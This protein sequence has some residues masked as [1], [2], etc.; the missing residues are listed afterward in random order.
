M[1]L[2]FE[3]RPKT[4]DKLQKS[5]KTNDMGGL[6]I[7]VGIYIAS[8]CFLDIKEVAGNLNQK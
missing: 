6:K 2:N 4:I 8:R 5:L 1:T 3:G 7:H